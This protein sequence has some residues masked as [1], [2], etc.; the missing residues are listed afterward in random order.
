[1]LSRGGAAP[2]SLTIHQFVGWKERK[3]SEAGRLERNAGL[4]RSM[5]DT[6]PVQVRGLPHNH[7]GHESVDMGWGAVIRC[8]ASGVTLLFAK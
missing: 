1:M 8:H 6:G 2:R 3:L 4:A 7:R 5:S